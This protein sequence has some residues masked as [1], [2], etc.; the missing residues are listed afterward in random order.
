M[1]KNFILTIALFATVTL[2]ACSEIEDGVNRMD[3]WEDEKI[4]VDYPASFV[5]P[6]IMHTNNDI[7]RLREIVT[8]R[9]QPDRKSV[10]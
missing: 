2:S 3:E 6:G 10:V 1:K 4:E 9:E 7:E 8:N 5:H